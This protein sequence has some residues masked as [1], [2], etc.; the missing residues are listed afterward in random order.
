MP[1]SQVA[2]SLL[3]AGRAALA[4]S[5]AVES[6]TLFNAVGKAGRSFSSV[7][8]RSLVTRGTST[9][10]LGKTRCSCG[11]VFC[12]GHNSISTSAT[13]NAADAALADEVPHAPSLTAR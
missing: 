5:A 11:K 13:A 8:G 6:Q 10:M 12:N 4:E 3:A 7:A 1:R 9:Q 2:R